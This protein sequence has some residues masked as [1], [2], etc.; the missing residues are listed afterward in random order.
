MDMSEWLFLCVFFFF[1]KQKTAYEMRI[2]DWSSDVCSSDLGASETCHL[3]KATVGGGEQGP[4]ERRRNQPGCDKLVIV[5]DLLVADAALI[6]RHVARDDALVKLIDRIGEW[7]ADGHRL[8]DE[9]GIGH[10]AVAEQIGRAGAQ[11][12]E[13]AALLRAAELGGKQIE[14][15]VARQLAV[16]A[17]TDIIRLHLCRIDID[18]QRHLGLH[19]GR[20]A[21]EDERADQYGEQAD[22]K[23]DGGEPVEAHAPIGSMAALHPLAGVFGEPV[24]C[25]GDGGAGHQS[26]FSRYRCTMRRAMRLSPSVAR[27]R[28]RKSVG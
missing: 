2:S 16:V 24:V 4:V 17:A 19:E 11:H 8:A 27:N 9:G 23:A 5:A 20:V 15:G 7:R 3:R 18:L 1:F 6:L 10:H 25:L 12:G 13:I 21:G 14:E 22:G 28:K 26:Y